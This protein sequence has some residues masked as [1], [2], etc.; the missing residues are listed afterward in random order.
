MKT[1]FKALSCS[2]LLGASMSANADWTPSIGYASLSD[3]SGVTDLSVGA[4]YVGLGYTFEQ[5]AFTIM[6]QLR[7]GYG[8]NDDRIM[9]AKVEMDNFVAASVRGQYNVTESFGLFIQ[10][11]YARF[12]AT[13]SADGVSASVK[14]DWEFGIGGGAK[15]VVDE[16][17]ALEAVYET[18]DES[19][20]ISVG[21]RIT[22]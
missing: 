12:R 9:N 20:V 19:D 15:Y 4:A 22:F 14:S 1:L 16:H 21:L 13:V 6:P 10:P 11:S 5:D 8:I 3:D 17:T 18:F 2:L 7:L